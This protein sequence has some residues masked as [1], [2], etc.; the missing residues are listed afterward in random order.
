M[1]PRRAVDPHR[2][3]ST[4]RHRR[5][6]FVTLYLAI[7]LTLL[8]GI[9]SL[10]VDLGIAFQKRSYMQKAADAS[11][12][13]GAALGVKNPNAT[14]G[15]IEAEA[16]SFATTNYGYTTTN[17]NK[18]TV[19]AVVN[20]LSDGNGSI[21]VGIR[22]PQPTLFAR[23][24][25]LGMLGNDSMKIDVMEIGA[26]ATA[27]FV[28]EGQV[29]GG[30]SGNNDSYGLN[31]KAT[32]NL[33]LVGPL[34]TTNRGDNR[35]SYY[36]SNNGTNASVKVGGKWFRDNS[37]YALL[38]TNTRRPEDDRFNDSPTKP[39]SEVIPKG[40][41]YYFD[42]SIPANT[43]V[44]LQLYDPGNANENQDASTL[45]NKRWNET[46]SSTNN[47]RAPDGTMRA[48]TTKTRF[49]VWCDM[50]QPNDVT[51]AKRI[52]NKLYG[53]EAQYSF[54]DPSNAA[55]K[56]W[57]NAV[58]IDP[59]AYPAGSK[60]Y[61]N[62]TTVDGT[63]KNGFNV[64]LN[65][66]DDAGLPKDKD[67]DYEA[68]GGNG[69]NVTT[70]GYLPINFGSNGTADLSM[71]YVPAG[72]TKVTIKRFDVD[73]GTNGGGF[74]VNYKTTPIDPTTKLPIPAQ[75]LTKT[76]AFGLGGGNANDLTQT[77]IIDLTQMYPGGYPGGNWSLS[78]GAGQSDQSTWTMSYI[79]PPTN[80]VTNIRLTD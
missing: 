56:G 27:T 23:I 73:V 64:R 72:A 53:D 21:V 12:L 36:T 76:G 69:T 65:R 30:V 4:K 13:A 57:I 61:L 2:L 14:A 29:F 7:S 32:A 6:G 55:N 49:Q 28:T 43:K 78:Y 18:V 47:T 70:R 52:F 41:G 17:D 68:V 5:R 37:D 10:V 34:A 62:S 9:S 48:V 19:T 42:L 38:D 71:G 39:A 46:N 1:K 74:S 16:I 80:A 35:S 24:F 15:D 31:S 54:D 60:F 44:A 33:S 8:L 25:R 26:R 59:S 67:T 40:D 50:G 3:I 77:D 58:N 79:G 51:K 45:F 66:L 20:R 11:A 75:A 63:G 22:R